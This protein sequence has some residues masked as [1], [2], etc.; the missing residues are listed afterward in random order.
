MLKIILHST[1]G[2][3]NY[4]GLNGIEIYDHLGSPLIKGKYKPTYWAEP[5]SINVMYKNQAD[6]RT[7]DKLFN[8]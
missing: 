2:D 7:I 5:S 1:W 3:L 4:C 8:C 6:I